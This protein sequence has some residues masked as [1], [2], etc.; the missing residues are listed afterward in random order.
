MHGNRGEEGQRRLEEDSD[1][2]G[3]GSTP[4]AQKL[5]GD[6]TRPRGGGCGKADMTHGRDER[7]Y[8]KVGRSRDVTRLGGGGCDEA[9][10][11]TRLGG[12][13]M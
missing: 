6:A 13:G 1:M 7:G 9:G 11:V 2:G 12:A 4:K 10:D 5:E 3:A 8:D